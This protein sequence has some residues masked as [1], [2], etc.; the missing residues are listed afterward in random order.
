MKIE[1]TL[2]YKD[3][4]EIPALLE[5]FS[6][7][8]GA[9]KKLAARS[10]EKSVYLVGRGSSG[11]ATLFAKYIWE[12]YAGT[13]TNFIHPHSIFEARKPLN[14]KGQAAWAFSQSGRSHDITACLEKLVKWGAKGVAV[15]NEA[16]L[17]NN[18]LARLAG[19]HILLSNSKELPV[20]ATKSFELQLWAVLWTAQVWSRC[21]KPADFKAAVAAARAELA[22]KRTDEKLL[23]TL[24]KAGMIGF[25]GRGAYNAVAEDSALKFR[26]MSRTH[27]LGYSAAEFLH[28]PVG[29]FTAK[30]FVF[31]FSPSDTVPED[32]LKVKKALDER[33]TT[34][35]VVKPGALRFP[36]NCLP[37]DMR[38]KTLALRLALHKGLNPDSPKG[39]NKVTLT[40]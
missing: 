12:G 15:T 29:A 3:I 13:I 30:D 18:P 19:R 8:A 10:K 23:R 25:V 39:L 27:A 9:L 36:F 40:F 20:A 21:F 26:E 7:G 1:D 17:K 38:M 24:A 31:L 32:I 11:T 16:D 37:V 5:K 28:G 34:F 2:T 14:F 35:L 6:A 22:V 33:G 4:A